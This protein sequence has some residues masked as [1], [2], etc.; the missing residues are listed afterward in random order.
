MDFTAERKAMVDSVGIRE[1]QPAQRTSL[2]RESVRAAR[3]GSET[4]QARTMPG[5]LRMPVVA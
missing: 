2:R 5:L 1:F 4:Q 3:A